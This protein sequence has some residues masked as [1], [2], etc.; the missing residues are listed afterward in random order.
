MGKQNYKKSQSPKKAPKGDIKRVHT[1]V[2]FDSSMSLI[3][4]SLA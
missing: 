4:I 1:L 3:D 2:P